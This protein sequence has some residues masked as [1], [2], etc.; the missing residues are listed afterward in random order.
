M[1]PALERTSSQAAASARTPWRPWRATCKLIQTLSVTAK[2]HITS[3]T[4]GSASKGAALP[5]VLFW[6]RP[7]LLVEVLDHDARLGFV[8][9]RPLCLRL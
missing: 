5:P 7:Q 2:P 1:Q 8:L 4:R 3:D 9:L 6:G